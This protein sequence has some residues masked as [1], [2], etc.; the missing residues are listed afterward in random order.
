[1]KVWNQGRSKALP[2]AS[3]ERIPKFGADNRMHS[4][5]R[6]TGIDNRQ[7]YTLVERFFSERRANIAIICWLSVRDRD[8]CF[9]AIF[10]AIFWKYYHQSR[11]GRSGCSWDALMRVSSRWPNA[12]IVR[13][14]ES[15]NGRAGFGSMRLK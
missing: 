9:F 15:Q 5:I 12:S 13:R 7:E 14:R 10:Q 4:L 1:M 6:W 8:I 3:T 11:N 2:N